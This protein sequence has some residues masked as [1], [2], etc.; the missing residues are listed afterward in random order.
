MRKTEAAS[1]GW[2]KA[3]SAVPTPLER[4]DQ[5]GLAGASLD[6]NAV[7]LICGPPRKTRYDHAVRLSAPPCR[8]HAGGGDRGRVHVAPSGPDG[9]SRP[10][11]DRRRYGAGRRGESAA[12]CRS[13]PRL[14]LRKG[15]GLLFL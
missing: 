9:R 8:V 13:A 3:L 15:R 7:A 12:G 11:S 2:A 6:A 10:P 1:A 4:S 5:P 14:L